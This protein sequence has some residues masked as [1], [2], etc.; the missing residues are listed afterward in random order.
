MS[1]VREI[2]TLMPSYTNIYLNYF[3]LF[4]IKKRKLSLKGG[5]LLVIYLKCL[6]SY[7]ILEVGYRYVNL[8][9]YT[10]ARLCYVKRITALRTISERK[11]KK[12]TTNSVFVIVI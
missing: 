8:F 9:V 5:M 3:D 10:I 2:I 4:V 12:C 7:T 1:N 11:M 6:I